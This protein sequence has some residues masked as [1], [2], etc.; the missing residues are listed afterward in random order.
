[1]AVRNFT[2]GTTMLGHSLAIFSLRPAKSDMIVGSGWVFSV[3]FFRMGL[4]DKM[5]VIV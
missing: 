4:Q 1:M 5:Q 3:T 2:W